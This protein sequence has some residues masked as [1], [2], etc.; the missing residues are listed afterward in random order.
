MDSPG[1]YQVS[2]S[3]LVYI[4][5]PLVYRMRDDLQYQ[6]VINSNKTV[7]RVVDDLADR[8]HCWIFVKGKATRL[9]RITFGQV[10]VQRGS[11]ISYF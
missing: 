4:P 3:H 7:D 6:R 10:K 8:G 9:Y 2:E 5:Q 1:V 11:L